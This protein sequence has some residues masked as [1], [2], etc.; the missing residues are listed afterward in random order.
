MQKVGGLVACVLAGLM[1][2]TS[3]CSACSTPQ[4]IT[5]RGNVDSQIVIAW[6]KADAMGLYVVSPEA[7]IPTGPRQH[8]KGGEVFWVI[9][10]TRFPTGFTSPVTYG[11]VPGGGKDATEEHGGPRG[12]GRL[13][14]GLRYKVAVV[15]L[16]GSDEVLV[17]WDCPN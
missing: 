6:Q 5:V 12:G 15:S 9:E 3:G 10:A 4:N 17:T 2:A 8:V 16:G 11:Q 14:C 7:N 13:Q 1:P